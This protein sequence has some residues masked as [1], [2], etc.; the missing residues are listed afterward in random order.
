MPELQYHNNVTTPSVLIT[1]GSGLVGKYLTSLLLE[2]GYRVAHLS[3]NA[4]Q[5]GVV[6]VFRWNPEK[7]ILDPVVFEGIDYVVH[8]AGANMGGSRWTSERKKEIVSSRVESAML[9]HKVINENKISLK[10]FITGYGTGYYGSVNSDRIFTEEDPAS[11]D[12][13]GTVCRLMDDTA[14]LFDKSGIRTVKLRTGVVLEKSNSALTK[15][16]MTE[17]F[18]F[19]ARAGIGNQFMPWIH[20]TDLCNIYL[21]AIEDNTMTGSYNAVS[22]QHTTHSD[23]VNELGRVLKKTVITVPAFTVSVMFGEM[24]VIV[25]RGSRVSSKKIIDSGYRFVFDD[26]HEAMKD[27]FSNPT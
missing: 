9:L 11:N 1:G 23:F 13:T 12:F 21:K 26:L 27:I 16:R 14:D 8:L 4:N 20:I 3:R 22:P 6:R 15:M 18:G 7:K 19:L 5:F 25:L 17:K 2:N 24:S 10:G